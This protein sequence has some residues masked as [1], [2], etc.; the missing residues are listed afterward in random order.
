MKNKFLSMLLF[1]VFCIFTFQ[2][3][4]VYCANDNSVSNDNINIYSDAGILIDFKTGN[5][6]YSKNGDERRYP[7]STTKILTAILAIE[8][9]NL[10]DIV[11]VSKSA[12][13]SI[14]SGYSSAYLSADEEA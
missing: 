8:K 11:T 14:P 13:S 1:F 12:V 4:F 9:C 3:N 10:D 7:A 5:I 6:L 2:S